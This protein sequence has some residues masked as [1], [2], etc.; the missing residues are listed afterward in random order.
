MISPAHVRA[1]T[2]SFSCT[3]ELDFPSTGRS[4]SSTKTSVSII[5]SSSD[6]ADL[7]DVVWPQS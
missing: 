4:V 5:L 6:I 3:S 1:E 2:C 7:K